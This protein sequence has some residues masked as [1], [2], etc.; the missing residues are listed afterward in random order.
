M[1]LSPV[2]KHQLQILI[3]K[4]D[5]KRMGSMQWMLQ[6]GVCILQHGVTGTA[7]LTWILSEHQA[8]AQTCGVNTAVVAASHSYSEIKII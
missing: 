2:L 5:H 8:G 4:N 7:R 1:I 3:I 6:C